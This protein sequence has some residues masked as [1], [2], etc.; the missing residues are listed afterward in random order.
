M[1]QIKESRHHI[2]LLIPS[3]DVVMGAD[4]RCDLSKEILIHT[5]RMYL[6]ETTVP[7]EEKMLREEWSLENGRWIFSAVGS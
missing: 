1:K 4:L 5:A 7:G 6:V 3:S 2:G